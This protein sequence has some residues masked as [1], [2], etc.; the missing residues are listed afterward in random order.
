MSDAKQ[1]PGGKSEVMTEYQFACPECSQEISVNENVREA[2]ITNG[3]PVCA[4]QVDE[5]E[6]SEG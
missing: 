2:I 3:C 5:T 4:A 6:F 1:P